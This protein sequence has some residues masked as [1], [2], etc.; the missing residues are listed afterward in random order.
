MWYDN[1][2]IAEEEGVSKLLVGKTFAYFPKYVDNENND[3]NNKNIYESNLDNIDDI[4]FDNK[5]Y[6]LIT[7]RIGRTIIPLNPELLAHSTF[8]QEII[9]GYLSE[10]HKN[11]HNY[12]IL[13]EYSFLMNEIPKSFYCLPQPD[14]LL[15]WDVFII[16]YSTFYKNGK[17]KL[18]IRLGENY[19]HSIPEV[20]FLTPV[21]HP[22][23]NP[24]T[25]KLNL[26]LNLNNWNPTSH[27]M[28]LIFLYIKSIFYLQDEYSK[29]IIENE[30]AYFLFNNNKEM[31]LKNVK[32]SVE[33]SNKVLYNK[34][35]N[36]MFNFDKNID[37]ME[38][39]NKLESIKNDQ[40]CS[41][42]VEAF[43]H[44]L[45]ND[46]PNETN[47]ENTNISIDQNKENEKKLYCENK[48]DKKNDY[49]EKDH[50][51]DINGKDEKCNE[52]D[53]KNDYVEK[54]EKID[55]K[56][57]N[58]GKDE[59]SNENEAKNNYVVK[60]DKID[61][62]NDNNDKDEKS[63]ENDTKNDY[64]EKEDKIDKKNDNNGKDEKS[65]ENDTKNDYVEKKD[66]ID[67]KNDNNGKDEKSNKNGIKN[68][69]VEKEDKIDKKNDNCDK[70]ENDQKN[71]NTIENENA[72]KYFDTTIG[73]NEGEKIRRKKKKKS[74]H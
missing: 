27:Y 14:N 17:F 52:N 34:I 58:N 31:F 60:E 11:V 20:Y 67:K 37:S 16:L 21:Y 63:N 1:E 7:Q 43:I 54:E 22:L 25:G 5:E 6:E 4:R 47:H 35:D 8:D 18:Q 57:D 53:T 66:K 19:P 32:K 24:M 41:K 29:E 9:D 15:V 69:Y 28:S 39:T 68:D 74:K 55:K 61:K 48:S 64:V 23:I 2:R 36:C 38:I 10:I 12:S 51:N 42:K 13:T 65:N 71:H 40:N 45:I 59:K 50:E 72:K 62:K 70:D 73:G 26:G 3:S 30:E 49:D 33:E 46:Y 56:N 44:W